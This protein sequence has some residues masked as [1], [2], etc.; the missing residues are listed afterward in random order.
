MFLGG[1]ARA[2]GVSSFLSENNAPQRAHADEKNVTSIRCLR[3]D[4][5][6]N[7]QKAGALE[8]VRSSWPHKYLSEVVRLCSNI[9]L[10][11]PTQKIQVATPF[12]NFL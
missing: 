10:R 6:P 3:I 1:A 11:S 2:C 7:F 8:I 9:V 12:Q 5:L 4:P